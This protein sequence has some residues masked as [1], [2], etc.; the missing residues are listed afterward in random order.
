MLE[1]VK[2]SLGS[3]K[4]LPP[5]PLAARHILR[6]LKGDEVVITELV[7]AVELDPVVTARLISIANSALFHTTHPCT[8]IRDAIVR[9]GLQE[10]KQLLLPIVLSEF[11]DLRR[12]PNFRADEY[13]KEI[14]LVAIGARKLCESAG[15]RLDEQIQ[16]SAYSAG[17]LHNIGLLA[18][19]HIYPEE[20]NALFRQV[21]D[22]RCKHDLVADIL[23][24]DTSE[25]SDLLLSS[26]ELPD[27][28]TVVARDIYRDESELRSPPTHLTILIRFMVNWYV[29]DFRSIDVPYELQGLGIISEDLMKTQI[30]IRRDMPPLVKIAGMLNY[31]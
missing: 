13:W 12:C 29:Q 30:L 16:R 18:L 20:M 31:Y 17:L 22:I 26:W 23:G 14:L 15:G 5:L 25:A 4:E 10:T 19:V 2:Q 21:T 6:A 27:E 24:I 9:L 28:I 7:N 8:N 3:I 11:F 1:A